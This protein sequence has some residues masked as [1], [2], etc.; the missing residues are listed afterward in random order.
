MSVSKIDGSSDKWDVI[1]NYVDKI[2][3]GQPIDLVF[4]YTGI[5]NPLKSPVF[6][7]LTQYDNVRFII[8]YDENTAEQIKDY[9]ELQGLNTSRVV[10]VQNVVKT[11][12]E[13]YSQDKVVWFKRISKVEEHD[14]YIDI[15]TTSSAASFGTN[16][17]FLAYEQA[18]NE[19][20]E[21]YGKRIRK[22]TL[23]FG[24]DGSAS[25]ENTLALFDLIIK[26]DEQGTE[27]ETVKFDAISLLTKYYLWKNSKM[28]NVKLSEKVKYID[29]VLKKNQVVILEKRLKTKRKNCLGESLGGRVSQ[30][31]AIYKGLISNNRMKAFSFKSFPVST[32]TTHFD[33]KMRKF[34]EEEIVEDT[35]LPCDDV[36]VSPS[37]LESLL[38]KDNIILGDNY[39]IS[40]CIQTSESAYINAY[41]V[42]DGK[43]THVKY[44][45]PV[46][47][48]KVLDE[49]G[50]EY[51][52]EE[53]QK[54]IEATEKY[55]N[56]KE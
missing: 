30:R 12:K 17:I 38:D 26:L 33:Y 5:S 44:S 42:V 36:L 54:D 43:P 25:D 48:K 23:D 46:F 6:I 15:I 11:V 16:N 9:L 8:Y 1:K 55:L 19:I 10:S 52:E 37:D 2:G 40:R 4:W 7:E 34:D 41:D 24:S 3:T 29:G 22:V 35:S 47:A 14:D 50:V 39:S 51:N 27:F 31:V 49:Y 13:P 21:K 32:F 56:E 53:L 28:K 45:I 18:L 20:K